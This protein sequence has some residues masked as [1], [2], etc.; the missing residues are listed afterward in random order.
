MGKGQ[1]QTILKRCETGISM[2]NGSD[3]LRSKQQNN[4]LFSASCIGAKI[5][6]SE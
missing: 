3:S 2:R 4:Y 5:A 6:G 1:Q